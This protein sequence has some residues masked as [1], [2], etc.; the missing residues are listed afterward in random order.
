SKVAIKVA[1][2][3]VI[4]AGLHTVGYQLCS[5]EELLEEKPE[6]FDVITCLE[7]LE[8]VPDP[9]AIIEAAQALVK[10]GGHVFLST[11][12]RNPKA[13]AQ[14]IVGAEYLLGLI[15]KGTHEYA[16]LIRP[17]ELAG[18]LRWAGLDL[19]DQRGIAYNPITRIARLNDDVSVNYIMHCT[20]E[21]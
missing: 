10:P 20:K 17:S 12:N 4:D 14:L 9:R 7:V 16:K 8:H 18:W 1:T 11:I 6:P 19:R 5:I 3:H 13:F 2:Q 15:P 21:S